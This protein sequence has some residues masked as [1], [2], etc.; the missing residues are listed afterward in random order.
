MSEESKN[1]QSGLIL[2]YYQRNPNRDIP[3]AE[4][5]D[6][7]TAEWEK[8]TGQKFRD[9]DRA[10]R[11]LY[12]EGLLIKVAKGI[13]RYD[14]SY[15]SHELQ[16]D[17][18]TE[19]KRKILER[20]GYRCVYCGRGPAEGMELHVDHIKPK[21]AGGKATLENGQTLCS[22]HNIWKKAYNQTESGKRLFI[23]LL[24][25]AR[26]NG[27]SLMELFCLRILEVYDEFN[28]NGHIDWS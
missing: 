19:L 20:D 21:S 27:D 24:D 2:A 11:K 22:E 17:F 8:L 25:F 15:L 7:A 9:P 28:I 16:E 18:T 23:R 6:W 10:I 14:P 4:I 12:S 13:Y 26:Q 1:T 5:V 3:H